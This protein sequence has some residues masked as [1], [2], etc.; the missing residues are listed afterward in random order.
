VN[1]QFSVDWSKGRELVLAESEPGRG[2]EFKVS[3]GRKPTLYQYVGMVPKSVSEHYAKE[4]TKAVEDFL[5]R[6]S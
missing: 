1:I 6:H 2:L 5:R 4:A 3:S